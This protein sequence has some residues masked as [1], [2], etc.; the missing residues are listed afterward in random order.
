YIKDNGLVKPVLQADT[1]I[2]TGAQPL[3]LDGTLPIPLPPPP[4][5]T[6]TQDYSIAPTN[7]AVSSSI[8]V[9]GVQPAFLDSGVIRSVCMNITHNWDDDLDIF[10]ITPGGQFLELSTDNGAD[11]NNY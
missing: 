10:L 6:N 8:N 1:T 2:C 7:T 3:Q 9:F 5:F 4:S 11:G